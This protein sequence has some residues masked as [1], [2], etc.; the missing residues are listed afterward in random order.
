[1][2]LPRGIATVCGASLNPLRF[3]RVQAKLWVAVTT[4]G[5]NSRSR[6]TPRRSG[7]LQPRDGKAR[8]AQLHAA[9]AFAFRLSHTVFEAIAGRRPLR[10]LVARVAHGRRKS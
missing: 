7:A 5:R 3:V 1:M 4:R 8:G 2:P 6:S 10:R 9:A